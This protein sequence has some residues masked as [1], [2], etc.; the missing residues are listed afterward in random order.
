MSEGGRPGVV[1]DPLARAFLDA[2]AAAGESVSSGGSPAAARARFAHMQS[3][4][5]ALPPAE[6]E[7]HTVPDG[8]GGEIAITVVRPEDAVGSVPAIIYL[9]GGGWVLGSYHTHE[10]LVRQLAVSTGAAVVVVD[11]PLAPEARYPAALD[12]SHAAT[13][14]VA[15]RGLELGL[16]GSRLAIAGDGAG[17]ALAAGVTLLAG[18]RGGPE[19]RCQVLFHP[20]TSARLNTGSAAEFAAGHGLTRAAMDWCW[21][22]YA[23]DPAT[24]DAPT[25]APL[26]A[27][28]ARLRGLPPALIITA[29]AD[30]LRDEGEAYGQRLRA[31]G[32]PVTITRYPG[33][34]HGFVVLNALADS[35]AARAAVAGAARALSAA[36]G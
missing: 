34:I 3:G 23:P 29:E 14:W 27:P 20:V 10:R 25:A 36:L 32:V 17:G 6:V 2:H 35:G 12:V 22:Q 9:H 8:A 13:R 33:T 30:V 7:P 1:L 28:L 16:D 21:A 11:Y 15:E 31:A 26:L 24:R 18:A 19:V 5:V 4:G